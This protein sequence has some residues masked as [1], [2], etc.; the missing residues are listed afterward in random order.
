MVRLEGLG[1]LRKFN[2]LIGTQT[3]AFRLVAQRPTLPWDPQQRRRKSQKQKINIIR[4]F[5]W[6]CS[7]EY[8]CFVFQMSQFRIS[9][10]HDVN[11]SRL[12]SI[13]SGT[14]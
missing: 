12:F 11:S 1:K 8:L 2:D 6:L 10:Y 14:R 13:P 4:L 5:E 3:R 9:D 7:C